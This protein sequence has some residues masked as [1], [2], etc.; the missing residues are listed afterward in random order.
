MLFHEA[1]IWLAILFA[2]V[3]YAFG[4][5]GL[6]TVSGLL[7]VVLVLAY[8]WNRQSLEGV[9]YE[10]WF[11]Y[12]RGFPGELIEAAIT[13][14]NR[15]LLPLV[16]LR[17]SDRWPFAVGP[18]D[19]SI[20]APSH[21]RDKGSLH[22]I[23]AMRGNAKTR[24]PLSLLL[25]GRGHYQMGPVEATSGDPF[26][27][28]LSHEEDFATLD[29]LV[30]FPELKPVAEL[31][32]DPDDPYGER[33]SRRELFED[34]TL[35][36][37]VRDYRPGDGFG[38]I[39]WPATARLGELQTR[40]YQPIQGSDL[41]ICLNVS[42]FAHHWEGSDPE[43]LE[44]LISSAASLVV[45]ASDQG[46]RVGLLS[47][48]SIAHAGKAFRIAPGRSKGQLPRLLGSLAGLT[49]VVTA[50]FERYLLDQAPSL[51]Y[52]SIF[53]IVTAITPPVLLEALARLRTRNRKTILIS[54]GEA[55]PPTIKGVN[56]YH[57]PPG[58]ELALS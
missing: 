46:Y 12:R 48:G 16:W 35:P 36:M 29:H 2:V 23:L 14:S 33:S 9:D 32:L 28:F 37:G 41:I 11:K 49:P 40:V 56:T 21:R 57:V 43:M 44:R 42:T 24:R 26:G 31:G 13:V 54:L 30:V 47:N 55:P 6:L 18:D 20:L 1:W 34:V 4:V 3:G 45:A 50:P 38:R 27:L 17:M 5:L 25:R 51:E 39:H 22:M 10:R 7:V 15:K 53:A 8:L 58:K 19:E 52:G